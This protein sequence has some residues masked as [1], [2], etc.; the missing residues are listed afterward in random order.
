MPQKTKALSKAELNK[1]LL[2]AAD[3]N[4]P[5]ALL[6]AIEH[7]ANVNAKIPSH[8]YQC[9]ENK[10]IRR[11]DIFNET[12]KMTE[13]FER[14]T[15]EHISCRKRDHG[16]T[17]LMVCAEK[18]HTQC[19][20]ILLKNTPRLED[21]NRT[22]ET[23]LIVAAMFE[24]TESMEL[25]VKHGA[26]VNAKD[27]RD[28]TPLI[29]TAHSRINPLKTAAVLLNNNADITHKPN[30]GNYTALYYATTFGN[31]DLALELIRRGAQLPETPKQSISAEVYARLEREYLKTTKKS[32]YRNELSTGL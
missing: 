18:N 10:L 1:L 6:Y 30:G 29:W 23:A 21:K 2:I 22:G 11:T 32:T 31:I 4:N 24:N 26:D 28:F 27:D 3:E 19:L 12:N 8:V 16:W 13:V 15:H 7:G 5:H 17:A 14:I 25:L 9:E 20:E